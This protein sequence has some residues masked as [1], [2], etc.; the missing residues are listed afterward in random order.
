MNGVVRRFTGAARR[1]D[2]RPSESL[3][4]SSIRG[5][6]VAAPPAF[7]K[8]PPI[9]SPQEDGANEPTG[10]FACGERNA[11]WALGAR[12]VLVLLFLV[13]SLSSQAAV[14][15]VGAL[16]LTVADL[17]SEVEFFTKVLPF[18]KISESKSGPGEANDLLGLRGTQLQSAELKLGDERIT[19]TEHLVNKGRPFPPDSRSFDHEC[20]CEGKVTALAHPKAGFCS[21]IDPVGNDMH[22]RSG[23]SELINEITGAK[24]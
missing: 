3:L 16:G 12:L 15:E 18:E 1:L 13:A 11:L 7:P 8:S 23:G 17:E 5:N 19:L 22:E 21:L 14:R 9:A 6:A 24:E 4:S 10:L 20:C 2:P